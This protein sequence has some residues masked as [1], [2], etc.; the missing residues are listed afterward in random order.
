MIFN[1]NF[2]KVFWRFKRI[3]FFENFTTLTKFVRRVALPLFISNR[4]TV[5]T[6]WEGIPYQRYRGGK[7]ISN[8]WYWPVRFDKQVYLPVAWLV[9]FWQGQSSWI[10]LAF[11]LDNYRYL[12]P[13]VDLACRHRSKHFQGSW[14]RWQ[15]ERQR[16]SMISVIC[17][18]FST[19][20]RWSLW[21]VLRFSPEWPVGT[22]NSWGNREPLAGSAAANREPILEYSSNRTSYSRC[23]E[24]SLPLTTLISPN[25]A[26]VVRGRTSYRKRY[27][28]QLFAL[29]NILSATNFHVF[30]NWY[31]TMSPFIRTKEIA[32]GR[33][34]KLA[35]WQ[36]SAS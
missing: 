14:R 17:S 34:D 16:P 23:T 32:F 11:F 24:N 6:P 9:R 5:R 15:S 13:R 27:Y 1:P 7:C 19:S 18:S 25:W 26:S 29:L 3:K 20:S 21:G 31:S 30:V 8:S 12:R 28:V 35:R 2:Y 22:R 4:D 10:R 33:V 36:A